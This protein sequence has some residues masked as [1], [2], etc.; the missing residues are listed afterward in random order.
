VNTPTLLVVLIGSNV[1][2]LFLGYLLGRLTRA[3]V[4]IEENMDTDTEAPPVAEDVFPRRLLH[5]LAVIV[6]VVGVATIALGVVVTV[7]Q[8][9][10]EIRDDRLTACITG[11]SNA[12][13]D[14]LDVRGRPAQE[15]TEQLDKVMIAILDAYD[16]VPAEGR[17][18]VQG[19][20]QGYVDARAQAK[21]TQAAHPYPDAPR[22]ACADL[23]N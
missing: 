14:T 7:A 13:A 8:R 6:A 16:D 1:A 2:C 15:A 3:T 4:R 18:K 22:D 12:L 19:A 17:L 11:Y 21:K 20:I 23:V 10:A 5:V 9:Q